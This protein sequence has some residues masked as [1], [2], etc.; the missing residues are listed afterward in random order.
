MMAIVTGITEKGE[1]SYRS[2]KNLGFISDK[3]ILKADKL[4]DL[5]S[6]KIKSFLKEHNLKGNRK[7]RVSDYWNFGEMLR[8][9]FFDS[10]LV[11]KNEKELF[12][13]N[14]RLHMDKVADIFPKNDIKRNRNIPKQFFK[15]A[16]YP[17]EIATRIEWAQ[18][19]FLFDYP[20]LMES[21]GFDKWFSQIL[22]S[23]KYKFNEG[24]T[25]LWAESF[26]LLFKNTDLENW[27]EQEKLKPIICTLEIIYGLVNEGV[28]IED[29]VVRRKLRSYI[30]MELKSH[31]KQFILMQMGEIS[32]EDFI[33]PILKKIISRIQL[34]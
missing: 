34:N 8:E 10:G 20:Y 33:N 23:D 12:F 17:F 4:D 14:V 15:L 1:K 18:W 24:F 28:K 31:K 27:S 9:L 5:I 2:I 30:T 22:K 29:R 16:G 3:D 32:K 19:S 7:S 25:R 26:I 11:D 13:V 21:T 6:K